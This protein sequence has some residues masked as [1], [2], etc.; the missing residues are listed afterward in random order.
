MTGRSDALPGI[1][2]AITTGCKVNLYLKVGPRLPDGY[3]ALDTFFLP[4]AEPHDT[5]RISPA[6]PDATETG[7]AVTCD[8]PGIPLRNNTLTR[9]YEAFAKATGYAPALALHLQKGVPH[10]AGLGGGSANAAGLLAYL[11]DSRERTGAPPLSPERLNGLAA[12]V[13]ADVPFFLLNAPARARG[14]GE[15]LTPTPNPVAGQSLVLV[16]PAIHISTA[17]AFEAL[18]VLRQGRGTLPPGIENN[19]LTRDASQATTCISHEVRAGNDFEEVVFP[20]FPALLHLCD[21]LREGG[22][23][24][25]QVS[26]TGSSVFGLFAQAEDAQRTAAKIRADAPVTVTTHVQAM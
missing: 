4:L 8:T 23:S 20:A 12:T 6:P 7:I 9:A 26:G 3:H 10:G 17:W 11:R 21:A 19:D 25:A 1:H 24:L 18:D 15:R 13:G 5:L 22:A 16:C 2:A 14:I